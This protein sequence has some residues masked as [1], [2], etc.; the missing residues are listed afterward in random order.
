MNLGSTA[1]AGLILAVGLVYEGMALYMPRGGLAQP[2][3]G[4]FPMIIGIFLVATALG[5]LLQ[6]ILPRK[7]S[8]A[9]AASPL[10]NRESAAP[11]DRNVTKTFQ[12]LAL[13]IGY[14]LLLKPLGFLI[15]ICTFLVVAIRIFG[16]RRWLPALAMAVVIAGISYVSF[17]LWLKVPLPLGIL[18][19]VFG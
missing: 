1:F 9:P 12:L 3:P 6:E 19:E 10:P 5:C 14:T 2:G 18:D 8:E 17:I 7:R 16:Y 13:M 15:S 11:G 4:F